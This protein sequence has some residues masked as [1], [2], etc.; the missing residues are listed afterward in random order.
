M[1][2]Y[3]PKHH[4]PQVL[5]WTHQ[6]GWVRASFSRDS[7]TRRTTGL[8]CGAG[9][10]NDRSPCL[11]GSGVEVGGGGCGMQMRSAREDESEIDLSESSED[12]NAFSGVRKVWNPPFSL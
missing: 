9:L 7:R 11:D 2:G 1:H 6:V 4:I 10:R 3:H 5:N 12:P 8:G